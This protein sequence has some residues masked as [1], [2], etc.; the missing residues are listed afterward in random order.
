[1]ARDRNATQRFALAIH[2]GAGTIA[3]DSLD[4]DTRARYE[5]AARRNIERLLGGLE[6]RARA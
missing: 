3:Q 6:T 4:V 5:Q 1:M 2:G